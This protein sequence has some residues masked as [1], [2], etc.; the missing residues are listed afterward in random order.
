MKLKP[1]GIAN[2]SGAEATAVQT[3]RE[4]HA[5]LNHANRL[6]CGAFT[7]AWVAT[8]QTQSVINNRQSAIPL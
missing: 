4:C 5:A 3:L 6:D 2:E 1:L 7:A 8:L